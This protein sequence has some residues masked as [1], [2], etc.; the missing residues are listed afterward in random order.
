MRDQIDNEG[1]FNN[2]DSM[3]NMIV[4]H[5]HLLLFWFPKMGVAHFD[6]LPVSSSKEF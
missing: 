5:I 4:I 3:I 6:D 1:Q 2:R